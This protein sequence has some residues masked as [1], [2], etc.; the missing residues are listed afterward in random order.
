[1]LVLLLAMLGAAAV[2]SY[3]GAHRYR[4]RFRYWRWR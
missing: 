1:M 3:G 2:W 4:Y